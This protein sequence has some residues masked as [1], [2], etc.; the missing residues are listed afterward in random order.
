MQF[1]L[2]SSHTFETANGLFA[3]SSYFFSFFYF[4]R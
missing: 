1:D 2:T 4:A 3:G